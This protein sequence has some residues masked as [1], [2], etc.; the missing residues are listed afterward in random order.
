MQLPDQL[1]A[2]RLSSTRSRIIGVR[3]SC[4]AYSIL[5]P[6]TTMVSGREDEGIVY[7]RQQ[8]GHVQ[9][10]R[11]G[12][13]DHDETFLRQRDVAHDEGVGSVHGLVRAE[14]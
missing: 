7:H 6:G 5:V 4:I 8:V 13:T 11:I 9:T 2:F 3:M 10:L 12:Q 1:R 14:N